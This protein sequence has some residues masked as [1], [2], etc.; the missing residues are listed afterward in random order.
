M[1]PGAER[2]FDLGKLGPPLGG[3]PRGLLIRHAGP[4]AANW[5]VG[6]RGQ[7]LAGSEQQNLTYLPLPHGSLAVGGLAAVRR[8]RVVGAAMHEGGNAD[9]AR[10]A[11]DFATHL[12]ARRHHDPHPV[13]P[14]VTSAKAPDVTAAPGLVRLPHL[15]T[16]FDTARGLF[17]AVVW[18]V[19]TLAQAGQW[20][21]GPIPDQELF[22][23]QLPALLHLRFLIR[24]GRLPE[25][26][27]G[28]RLRGLLAGRYLSIRMVYQHPALFAALIR[29]VRPPPDPGGQDD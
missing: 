7:V 2:I 10:L 4:V 9:L 12:D 6:G 17:D 25:S 20:L 3:L 23:Q 8:G 19:M 22:E 11:L 14:C 1:N 24:V 5:P 13:R 15:V 26:D 27:V 29:A 21:G 28:Q 16:L 18:E